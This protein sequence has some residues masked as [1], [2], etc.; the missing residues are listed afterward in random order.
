MEWVDALLAAVVGAR[1]EAWNCGGRRPGVG[2]GEGPAGVR[3]PGRSEDR[4]D[5][6]EGPCV[7]ADG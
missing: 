1:W 3:R 2:C 4:E 6:R 5:R 7:G